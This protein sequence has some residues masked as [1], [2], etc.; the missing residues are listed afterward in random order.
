MKKIF[1]KYFIPCPANCHKPHFLREKSI[2]TVLLVVVLLFF[3]SFLGRYAVEHNDFL[4]SIQSAYL[5]DLTNADRATLG[6]GSL[7][8]NEKLV[9][10]A[11]MKANDMAEKG[12]FAHVSPDGHSPWYWIEKAGYNYIYAGENLAVNFNQSRDVQ[13][14]WMNSPTHRANIVNKHYTEI[15]IS[16]SE[17]Y[18]KGYKTIF[19]AQVFASP[20]TR[21]T[22]FDKII[23]S[24]ATRVEAA[25]VSETPAPKDNNETPAVV[26][27]KEDEPVLIAKAEETE[28][29]MVLGEETN[30]I[31]KAESENTL[32]NEESFTSFSNPNIPAEEL[33]NIE[34]PKNEQV[35]VYT[36]WFERMIVS[37][38]KVVRG[39]YVIIASIITFALILKIFIEI[40]QQHTKHII[41][42]VVL[43]A[44]VILFIFLTKKIEPAI[45][46]AFGF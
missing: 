37:P 33:E 35:V 32:Q 19:V 24:T 45:V 31:A 6:L 40:R 23:D 28:D 9:N 2:V 14:A 20:N 8:I 30:I 38:T 42:G 36:N 18:Y 46:V 29:T 3:A 39:I 44:I 1:K 5:V 4:A 16:T 17:G 43:L 7:T 26:T 11:N 13:N 41:Y 21:N 27:Q 34:A 15:G 25:N 22:V 10:A 12:Y